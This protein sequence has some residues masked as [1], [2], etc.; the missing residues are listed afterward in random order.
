MK[1]QMTLTVAPFWN[2]RHKKITYHYHILM[3]L[4]LFSPFYQVRGG[5]YGHRNQKKLSTEIQI[6]NA[7][8]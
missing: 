2:H 6:L 4:N 8:N 5:W 1:L 3:K 7:Q